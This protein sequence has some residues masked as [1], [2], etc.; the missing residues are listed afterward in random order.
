MKESNHFAFEIWIQ[1]KVN[2]M[3]R[4]LSLAL[5]AAA[6]LVPAAAPSAGDL[7]LSWRTIEASGGCLTG[8]TYRLETAAGQP[9]ATILTGGGLCLSGGMF[10]ECDPALKI[11][12]PAGNETWQTGTPVQIHWWSDVAIAGTTVRLELWRGTRKL[13]TLANDTSTSGDHLCRLTLPALAG[14]PDCRLRG[15]STLL[16]K[17]NNPNPYTEVGPLTVTAPRNAA[18]P[19]NWVLYD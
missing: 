2:D 7:D 4:F 3:K 10:P 19:R 9:D 8:G 11:I 16:E 5:G 6:A 17:I 14:G 15:V 1:I 12:T 18:D 13:A